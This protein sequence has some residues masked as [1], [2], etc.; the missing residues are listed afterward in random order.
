MH[1]KLPCTSYP[2]LPLSGSFFLSC[3]LPGCQPQ[4]SLARVECQAFPLHSTGPSSVPSHISHAADQVRTPL[5]LRITNHT[6]HLSFSAFCEGMPLLCEGQSCQVVSGLCLLLSSQTLDLLDLTSPVS[7]TF[8][9][10]CFSPFPSLRF[11]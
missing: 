11:S 4:Q 2:L 10:R 8:S 9:L 6:T 3:P 7:A 5:L 1:Q